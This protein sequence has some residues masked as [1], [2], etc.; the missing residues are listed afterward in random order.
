MEK[1]INK[2]LFCHRRKNR[3]QYMLG[4]SLLVA[5]IFNEDSMAEYY[6]PEGKW[7]SLLTGEEKAG[8]RWYCEKHGYLSIPLYVKAGSIIA[9]G[10]RDDNAVYDY[11]DGTCLKVYALEDGQSAETSVY[12]TENEEVIKAKVTRIGEQYDIQVSGGTNVTVEIVNKEE[13]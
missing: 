9:L 7:T 6:L 2:S 13:N 10:G 1:Q 8:G 11:A 12:N 5:P 4:D 3:N